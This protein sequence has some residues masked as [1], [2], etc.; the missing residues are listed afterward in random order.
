M[1]FQSVLPWRQCQAEGVGLQLLE[2]QRGWPAGWQADDSEV[3][4][5]CP[6]LREQFE[7]GP[8][9]QLQLHRGVAAAERLQQ[10]RQQS[11]R[12]RATEAYSQPSCFAPRGQTGSD[13]DVRRA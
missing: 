6:D 11:H 3:Q 13:G 7:I 8:F 4:R 12:D 1:P 2:A 9:A 5:A 10:A